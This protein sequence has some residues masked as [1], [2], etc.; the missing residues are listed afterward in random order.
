MAYSAHEP[1]LKA[2]LTALENLHFSVG[3][4]R[5]PEVNELRASLERAGVAR[6]ADLP[7]RVLSAGQRRRVALA[8]VLATNASIW[9]LDEP[10]ANLDTAGGDLVS[11]LLQS[12]VEGGG[13]ALVVAHRDLD[14]RC[15]VRRL[16]LNS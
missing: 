9:L 16:E 6:C 13:L 14:L 4:K 11:E 5:R 8:R 15:P 3:L 12:H 1:A 7:A 10:Y 2:D